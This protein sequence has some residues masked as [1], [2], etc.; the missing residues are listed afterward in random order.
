[1]SLS[2]A[3]ESSRSNSRRRRHRSPATR[4]VAR[5]FAPY[6]GILQGNELLQVWALA[7]V[8]EAL[9][10]A[11]RNVEANGPLNKTHSDN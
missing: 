9:K 4:L 10:L 7:E 11:K 8:R 3:S 5:L 1:M 2:R 6:G